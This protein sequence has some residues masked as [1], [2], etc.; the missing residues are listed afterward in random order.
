MDRRSGPRPITEQA[1]SQGYRPSPLHEAARRIGDNGKLPPPRK[2]AAGSRHSVGVDRASAVL[3][4]T[5]TSH[6]QREALVTDVRRK[7]YDPVTSNAPV[8]E[9]GK[10][11]H[12]AQGNEVQE[13]YGTSKQQP[14]RTSRFE[15]E[16]ERLVTISIP[17]CAD[18]SSV[19]SH[20]GVKGEVSQYCSKE[21]VKNQGTAKADGRPSTASITRG[22]EVSMAPVIPG[23]WHEIIEEGGVILQQ[24][25]LPEVRGNE[26]ET[27]PL[28]ANTPS[29]LMQMDT[30]HPIPSYQSVVKEAK[31]EESVETV[32]MVSNPRVAPVKGVH[33][34]LYVNG[35]IEGQK[36][37]FLVDTGAEVSVISQETLQRL[38]TTVRQRFESS[39]RKLVTASGEE[40]EAL[41]PVLCSISVQNRTVTDTVYA[42]PFPE[43]AI[44]GITTL[45]ALGCQV[46]V[47]GVDV[48]KAST[49]TAVRSLCTPRVHRVTAVNDVTIPA[50]SEI[51]LVGQIHGQVKP[52]VTYLVEP[53]G[54]E[55]LP[56]NMIVARTLVKPESGRCLVQVCNLSTNE[57]KLKQG[58]NV[59]A[60][61]QGFVAHS[62]E[63]PESQ[64]TV[65]SSQ[66]LPEHLQALYDDTC[67]RENLSETAK[68]GLRT[69]LCKHSRLFAESDDDLGRTHLVQHDIQTSEAAPI[70][71]PPR[72]VPEAQREIMEEEVAKMLR[73]GVV[74]PGQSPWASPV[75]LVKKKDGSTRFCVDYRRLNTVTQFDAYPLPRID[76]TIDS[77]AGSK[78]FTTLDLLSGYWQVGLT[79][80]ARLKSAFVTRSGL[81]LWKVMPFGLCNAPA[82]FERLM[83]TVLRGLQWET[84]LVYLD[85]VVIFGRSEEELLARMDDVFTR[86]TRAGLKLKPRKCRLFARQCDYLGHVISGDGVT[87]SPEKVAAIK[88]WATPETVT[89]VRSF[90]GTASYYRRF[91][92]GFATVAAPLH[93]LTDNG[94]QWKWTDQEQEAFDKLKAALCTAPVLAYPVPGAPYVLDT[95]ASNTGIGAVLIQIIDGVEHVLGYAS[96]SLSK[97]ERNYCVTRK[98]LLAVVHFVRHFRP[99]LYGRKFVIRTDHSSLQWLLNFKEPDGQRARW[100]E[101]LSEY[102]YSIQHRPGKSHGNAD[103]LSRQWCGKCDRECEGVKVKSRFQSTGSGANPSSQ[104]SKLPDQKSKD[105][106]RL[107]QVQTQWT[108]EELRDFQ[109]ADQ[110][111][112]PL[113][114]AVR[115]QVKPGFV[116]E[117]SWPPMARRYLQ[118]WDRLTFENEVLRRRWY[119]PSGQVKCHQVIATRPMITA[120]LKA[121]HEA[122]GHFG[123]KRTMERIRDHFHWVGLEADV[124][125]WLKSCDVCGAR[126]GKPTRAHH[127]YER[128]AVSE[129]LQ[130]VAM[131]LLGP[132]DETERGNKY[133]LVVVDYLSKWVEGYPL[134]DMTATTCADVF[135]RE[136]VCR[137][138]FP[139]QVH[140]DQGRQFESA[141]FQEV[142]RLMNVSKSRTTPLHPQ[143]DGQTERANKTILDLLAKLVATRKEE[144]DLCLPIALSLYRSSVHSVTGETPNRLMLGREVRT[145]VTLLA[146]LPPSQDYETN[147]GRD[148]HARFGDMHQL[149][150][151]VTK[152]KHRAEAPRHDRRCKNLTFNEGD[153]VWVYDPKQRRGKTPKLDPNRWS[154]PWKITRKVSKCT[155][156]VKHQITKRD[157]LINVDRMWPYNERDGDRFPVGQNQDTDERSEVSN[158]DQN[159]NE[160][161]KTERE[162]EV[163]V[164]RNDELSE[165]EEQSPTSVTRRARRN[166]RTPRRLEDYDIN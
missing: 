119:S 163:I 19:T 164:D 95:D 136:F 160:D 33:T 145:P 60:A 68:A 22:D 36:V 50:Q 123:V 72:R 40:V 102:E 3:I 134:K 77:L 89:D 5:A 51:L 122:A 157:T 45:V 38:P 14:L 32:Q 76:E 156:C 111:L 92:P 97:T 88:D 149:V 37:K 137:Y 153:L 148:F 165:Q 84:C 151:E 44:L 162:S 138:G 7:V 28:I 8:T 69:L 141:L 130:R 70:R 133:I 55:S 27:V 17:V 93:R 2:T 47:A 117:A 150:T 104:A 65:N 96:R 57:I 53:D 100:L 112:Q 21:S 29:C 113:L 99:Y 64:T 161:D 66:P 26:C 63:V 103:G 10:E 74:E 125:S 146:P 124:R 139:L 152:Q 42:A 54:S 86:L 4:P 101:T 73:Q 121:A 109:A 87:V 128:Q 129:P 131:D 105:T 30:P 166:R 110:H 120:I 24:V 126:R 20:A 107:L 58:S 159:A 82:T 41:G 71:Q 34:S 115:S 81:Y 114:T 143:S 52:D 158:G 16:I 6:S 35:N 1:I 98:E 18:K 118:D 127:P 154:G 116:E 144:W 15:G 79:E 78:F 46:T 62:D 91:V 85:D 155:Y 106:V 49:S 25:E 13:V 147:W 83:E 80:A 23:L 142:C 90:L 132:L 94:A 43:A 59:G 39:K 11:K 12:T 9:R 75:V 31:S 61:S 135:T 108:N 56:P 48:V 67:N 140:S